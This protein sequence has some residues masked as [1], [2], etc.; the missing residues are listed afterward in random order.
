MTLVVLYEPRNL[1]AIDKYTSCNLNVLEYEY[2]ALLQSENPCLIK[3]LAAILCAE[4]TTDSPI[5]VLSADD[6]ATTMMNTEMATKAHFIVMFR[7][8]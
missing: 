8:K 2:A 4:T 3:L 5:V 7:Q 1:F 6:I